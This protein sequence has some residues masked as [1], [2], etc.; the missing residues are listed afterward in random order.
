MV[1]HGM[2]LLFLDNTSLLKL[3]VREAY[4]FQAAKRKKVGK[5]F[6]IT[7]FKVSAQPEFSA[8]RMHRQNNNNKKFL[9][10]L[11]S[12]LSGTKTNALLVWTF[13]P[14]YTIPHNYVTVC[15][16]TEHIVNCFWLVFSFCSRDP[17]NIS[18]K[19]MMQ[20]LPVK[21]QFTL[22]NTVKI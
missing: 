1:W 22:S 18:H 5:E 13:P 20:H 17:S 2:S 14:L 11:S 10:G 21:N 6:I 4:C 16:K 8:A 3:W 15:V 19:E 7:T 12:N 9:L